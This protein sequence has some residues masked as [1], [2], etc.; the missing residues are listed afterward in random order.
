MLVGSGNFFTFDGLIY[1]HTGR[2]VHLLTAD[3]VDGNFSVSLQYETSSSS[4]SREGS[5]PDRKAAYNIIIASG[6]NT[7]VI[8]LKEDVSRCCSFIF[9]L[10]TSGIRKCLYI[11]L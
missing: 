7:L 2:C 8:D 5:Q 6:H 10:I 11:A 4:S 9:I 3:L 1:N